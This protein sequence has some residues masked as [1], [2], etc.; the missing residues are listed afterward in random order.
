MACADDRVCFKRGVARH[1]I[2]LGLYDSKTGMFDIQFL[3][4]RGALVFF[5][6]FLGR[7]TAME[8]GAIADYGAVVSGLS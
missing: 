8:A 7:Y 2:V 4:F 5:S 6:L 3:R 1:E